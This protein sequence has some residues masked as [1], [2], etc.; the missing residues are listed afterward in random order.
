MHPIWFGAGMLLMI[1]TTQPT[2]NPHWIAATDLTIEGRGWPDPKSPFVRLPDLIDDS[3]RP[4]LW[5]YSRHS[6]GI[7]VR[8]IT[9]ANQLNVRWNLTA[10]EIAMVGTPSKG[11]SG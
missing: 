8:F 7:T 11:V 9:P 6:S 3:G 10:K 5:D 2:T 1:T 4:V